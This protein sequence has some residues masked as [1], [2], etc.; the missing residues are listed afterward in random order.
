MIE[1]TSIGAFQDREEARLIRDALEDAGF[2]AWIEGPESGIAGESPQEWF[3]VQVPA[4]DA[5]EARLALTEPMAELPEYE[6]YEPVAAR[7]IWIPVAAAI[8]LV[9]LVMASV[10]A[11][12]WPWILLTVLIGFV[13][14][15]TIGP[16]HP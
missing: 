14:W 13:L 10:D 11:F 15:R 16:R 4:E 9:G 8:A 12:L 6:A 2:Q 5:D 7:P 1:R 3:S